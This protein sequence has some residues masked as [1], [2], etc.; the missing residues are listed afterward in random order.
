LFWH[1]FAVV[2]VVV[3]DDVAVVVVAAVIVAAAAVVDDVDV[4]LLFTVGTFMYSMVLR[5]PV[6]DPDA[7]S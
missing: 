1:E 5:I 2:V 7:G 3:D 4:K 6:P